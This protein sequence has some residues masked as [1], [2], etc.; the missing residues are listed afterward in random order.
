MSSIKKKI[1]K[2]NNLSPFTTVFFQINLL[3]TIS[4]GGELLLNLIPNLFKAISALIDLNIWA[5]LGPFSA[6]V[7]GVDALINALVY[8]YLLRQPPAQQVVP[9][10]IPS[11][12]T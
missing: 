9:S 11:L 7:A 12:Y 8:R 4:V 2:S 1:F 5:T 6:M 3:I 10:N